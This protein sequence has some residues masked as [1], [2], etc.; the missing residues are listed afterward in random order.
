MDKSV[1]L[2]PC[3][4]CNRLTVSR[5]GPWSGPSSTLQDRDLSPPRSWQ[6][7]PGGELST[8]TC[9]LG[10]RYSKFHQAVFKYQPRIWS[11]IKSF[12]SPFL[13]LVNA[14]CIYF[15]AWLN[16]CPH[17]E[18]C[19]GKYYGWRRHIIYDGSGVSSSGWRG[20]VSHEPAL[21]QNCR[22]FSGPEHNP[23]TRQL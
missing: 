15:H 23:G 10:T 14:K 20:A 2:V 5:P 22:R 13:R 16:V 7:P 17:I 6:P 12:L 3:C 9:Q 8:L 21:E 4:M 1:M 11:S 18:R 19:A